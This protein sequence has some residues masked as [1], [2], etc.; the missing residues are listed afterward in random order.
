MF[1]TTSSDAENH[2]GIAPLPQNHDRRFDPVGAERMG[3]EPVE[4]DEWADIALAI[5]D[6]EAS[7]NDHAAA[8]LDELE[9]LP[10][11][12]ML[13]AA[14]ARIDMHDLSPH[15]RVVVLRAHQRMAS[16][17]HA[18]LY[19]A[20][21]AITDA[22]A[23][24]TE[25]LSDDPDVCEGA[26]AE[27]RV[28]LRWTR[29]ATDTELSVAL[30]LRRRLPIVFQRMASGHIDVRRA[31]TFDH[32]TIDLPIGTARDIADRLIDEA[33][34]LT[35]G[36][37]AAKIR[38]LR[39]ESDPDEA[40]IRMERSHADRRVIFETTPD[41]TADLHA[42]GLRPEKA[43][44]LMN[45]LH[46]TALALKREGDDRTMDQIRADVLVDLPQLA[47]WGD[48][49]AARGLITLHVDLPTLAHMRDMAGDLNGYGP[50]IADIARQLTDRHGDAV[51]EFTV[52]DGASG[53]PIDSGTTRRRPTAGQRRMARSRD[54]RCVF[55]GCRVPASESDLDHTR[56]WSEG[57]PTDTDNLAPLCRHDHRIRHR[58]R[59]RYARRADGDYAWLSPMGHAY[60]TSGRSP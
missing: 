46:R 40:K 9:H 19:E 12:T 15:D 2:A 57:G 48:R 6:A 31:K 39:V 58:E 49:S 30:A 3:A 1:D 60:T 43:A 50:V 22:Y 16:H 24:E 5:T 26:A 4:P 56:P 37:L 53:M 8:T 38:R 18:K 32:G 29:R 20:M 55:P 25:R 23:E 34:G 45:C 54:R 13:A 33:P 36:E 47:S 59:W 51:W 44:E 17:H 10:P 28:A 52:E 41:G 7:D 21:G 42:F 14:L 11:G 35:T 27:I